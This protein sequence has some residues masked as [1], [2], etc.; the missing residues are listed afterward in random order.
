[1]NFICKDQQISWC[2]IYL[3]RRYTDN[4]KYISLSRSSIFCLT[5]YPTV[6]WLQ[7]IHFISKDVNS[8]NV[9]TSFIFIFLYYLSF[10][11]ISYNDLFS[12]FYSYKEFQ[13]VSTFA[14]ALKINKHVS[15]AFPMLLNG[16]LPCMV[17]Q[18][19]L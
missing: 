10:I 14:F 2:I 17:Y 1:M 11:L 8:K 19:I 9:Y 3:A 6:L 5:S 7:K 15:I 16:A 18:I 4:R 13:A 12:I